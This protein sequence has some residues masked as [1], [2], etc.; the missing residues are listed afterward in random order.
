MPRK[1]APPGDRPYRSD[2]RRDREDATRWR[3]TVTFPDRTPPASQGSYLS[4]AGARADLDFYLRELASE[5]RR[6]ARERAR[7]SPEKL[8]YGE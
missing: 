5:A 6:A 1:K 3:W 2:V 8:L 4:E 7:S